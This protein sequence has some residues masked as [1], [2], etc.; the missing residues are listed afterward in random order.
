MAPTAVDATT[1]EGCLRH[2]PSLRSAAAQ[3]AKW[4][5]GPPRLRQRNTGRDRRGS[6][7]EMV[8]GIASAQVVKCRVR[9]MRSRSGFVDSA[10]RVGV[11]R[12]V[13]ATYSLGCRLGSLEARPHQRCDPTLSSRSAD[14]HTNGKTG[15]DHPTHPP[16]HRPRI[17]PRP[18]RRRP[19]R[20]HTPT[21]TRG[22]PTTNR[23]LRPGSPG[24]RI[25][26]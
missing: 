24:H 7:I 25:A 15:H 3:A 1:T 4:R 9:S 16:H 21:R 12:N 14:S 19:G 5:A 20:T 17:H 2:P 22:H 18:Q 23:R 11:Y 6:G 26:R 10:R 13:S 8:G